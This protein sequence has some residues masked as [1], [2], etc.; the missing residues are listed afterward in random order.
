MGISIRRFPFGARASAGYANPGSGDAKC[1]TALF[2]GEWLT[3]RK[4]GVGARDM[5][6][7]AQAIC[8]PLSIEK[9]AAT[10]ELQRMPA[11]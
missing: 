8:Q 9:A 4:S 2:L 10:A 7:E 11:S 3:L 5:F 1:K 6:L